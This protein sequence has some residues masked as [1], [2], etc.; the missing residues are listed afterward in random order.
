MLPTIPEN[1]NE[2]LK[3]LDVFKNVL[4]PYQRFDEIPYSWRRGKS[5][6]TYMVE[7]AIDNQRSLSRLDLS[8]IDLRRANISCGDFRQSKLVLASFDDTNCRNTNFE[9]AD[10]TGARFNNSTLVGAKFKNAILSMTTF[11]NNC[12]FFEADFEGVNF[13]GTI[14]N[15]GFNSDLL[16][17]Q[18]VKFHTSNNYGI[19]DLAGRPIPAGENPR[20]DYPRNCYELIPL[21]NDIIGEPDNVPITVEDV[22]IIDEETQN[23]LKQRHIEYLERQLLL[24]KDRLRLCHEKLRHEQL[25]NERLHQQY[26]LREQEDELGHHD[27]SFGQE[28]LNQHKELEQE[29]RNKSKGGTRNKSNSKKSK[30][31]RKYKRSRNIKKK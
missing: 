13:E 30:K 1:N 31:I 24:F 5:D 29:R 11:N 2:R 20:N 3:N 25:E 9:S 6:I 12:N 15:E 14:F 22:N 23:D 26:E 19:D 4:H 8:G 21:V 16:L 18:N 7:K 27:L 10:L 28:Q 17:N